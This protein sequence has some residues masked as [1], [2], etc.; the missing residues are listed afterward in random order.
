MLCQLSYRGPAAKRRSQSSRCQSFSEGSCRAL[1]VW[2]IA[3]R[4]N[5]SDPRRAGRDHLS[6]VLL[7]DA[8]DG[9]PGL[10]RVSGGVSDEV[11]AGRGSTLFR[12]R[13]VHRPDAD[14]VRLRSVDLRR[15]MGRLAGRKSELPRGSDR[16]IVLPEM[17]EVRLAEDRQVGPVVDDERHAEPPRDVA[18]LSETP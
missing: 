2:R 10:R 5:D 18:C 7:V 1:G 14:V 11:Q 17:H 9:E 8:T 12:R 13:L 16:E 4:A 6:D 15:G 3:D